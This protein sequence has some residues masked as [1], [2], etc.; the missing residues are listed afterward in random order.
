MH[1]DLYSLTTSVSSLV[2]D[3]T[4]ARPG[5]LLD[6][7]FPETWSCRVFYACILTIRLQLVVNFFLFVR[8]VGGLGGVKNGC[9][10]GRG[11]ATRRE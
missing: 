11:I 3:N 10:R 8:A 1:S 5:D 9:K 4:G 2:A 7:T 6:T